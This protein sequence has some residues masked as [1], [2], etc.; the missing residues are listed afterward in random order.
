MI[1]GQEGNGLDIAAVV[2]LGYPLKVRYVSSPLHSST[3]DSTQ[4]FNLS[5]L[6]KCR[7]PRLI[8]RASCIGTCAFK[9]RIEQGAEL[10]D[11]DKTQR[12]PVL[13]FG[14]ET[15][16]FL[17]VPLL[18]CEPMPERARASRWSFQMVVEA[19]ISGWSF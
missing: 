2:C 13:Y 17:P 6:A 19:D 7:V 14:L 3:L 12:C 10:T 15:T 16:L 5:F 18:R 4:S 1:G 9:E 8:R 11:L